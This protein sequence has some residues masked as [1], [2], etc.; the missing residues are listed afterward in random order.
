MKSGPRQTPRTATRRHSRRK[1]A[2]IEQRG[3]DYVPASERHGKPS[4]LF[5]MWAGAL[6]NIE[7]VVYGA[8]IISIGLSFWQ[9]F[10][11]I[12]LG[13][14]TYFIAGLGSLQGPAAGT[15]VFTITRAPYGPQPARGISAFNW[16]TQVGYEVEG[17]SLIVLAGL[18]L[19]LKA[20][21]S[22]STGLKILIIVLAALIQLIVPLFGHRTMMRVLRLLV[23]PFVVVFVILAVLALPKAHFSNAHGASWEMMMV[24]LALIA[25]SG[26]LG[27]PI[28]ASD[29]SRYLPKNSDRKQIVLAVTAGGYVPSV[30]LAL[31]GAAVATAVPVAS[32]P[33]SGL[34]HA[35]ASWFLVPYLILIIIQLFAINSIDLYSSGLTLQAIGLKIK[36]W[37]AVLV[38]TVVSGV[39]TAVVIFSASFNTF[40]TDFLL[41]MIIWIAPWV[42]IFLVDYFLRRGSYDSRSLLDTRAGVYWRTG[43]WHIPGV[44]AQL[45]GMVAAAM[46]LDTTVWQGPLS[47]AT[48]GADFS[49]FMGTIV[50]GLAYYLLARHSV[51]RE[52]AADPDLETVSV[53][54]GAKPS[55]LG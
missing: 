36:R 15:A 12:I 35:F 54:Q 20:G 34:P 4:D 2:G 19:A 17:L 50:G 28:N 29:Y 9:A 31:L 51:P 39:I 10:L 42:G 27:W 45:L 46:W 47:T 48:N 40:L 1:I 49:I 23:L 37:Q 11:I 30:L 32:D 18:A 5:W 6:W 14:L 13:N 8:L 7:Y 16:V 55:D 25:T 38:D 22:A 43:G 24:A 41:F 53:A 44:I 3:I 26:G 21:V 52:V 33:I